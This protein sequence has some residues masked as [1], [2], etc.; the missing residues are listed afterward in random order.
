MLAYILTGDVNVD[1]AIK[2]EFLSSDIKLQIF[3][4]PSELEDAL[5]YKTPDALI[6]DPDQSQELIKKNKFKI[7][8]IVALIDEYEVKDLMCQLYKQ[9]CSDVKIK[10]Q[11]TQIF[12]S[13]NIALHHTG[14][15]SHA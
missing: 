14:D 6:I 8:Y 12:K 5:L 13:V 11:A 10:R 15:L 4:T 7:P 2:R 3:K 1:D 9:G